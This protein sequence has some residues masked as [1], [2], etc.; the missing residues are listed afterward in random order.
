MH[1]AMTPSIASQRW[2][3]VLEQ[4]FAQATVAAGQQLWTVFALGPVRVA[5]PNFPMGLE[6]SDAGLIANPTEAFAVL[7][8]A[9]IDLLRLSAPSALLSGSTIKDVIELP[10]TRI[11]DLGAWD[12]HKLP[13]SLRR[14]LR[15]GAGAGLR[16]DPAGPSEGDLI[17]QLYLGTVSRHHGSVRYT[18][19]YFQAL[20]EAAV[21]D[22]GVQIAK[23][24]AGD[25][26]AAFIAVLHR[27][28]SSYY[29]H[30]GFDDAFS[31]IRPGYFA[32]AWAI[33]HARDRGSR[34]FEFL[35]SPVGQPAL[36]E[37]KE[38]FGGTTRPRAHWDVPLSWLGRCAVTL[39]RWRHAKP[40]LR[41][42]P[43]T[44]G[45]R[46]LHGAEQP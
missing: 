35:T 14:K 40:R 41:A 45:L 32:M 18:R 29:L 17:H 23:A 13:A 26:A 16:I 10:D 42:R 39:L 3:R 25:R 9:G 36:R 6:E 19:R 38:S 33:Q 12:A 1:S 43:T 21:G 7:R 5:Y 34:R 2:Q 24:M 15:K 4:G 37:Y 28:D 46:P 27:G 22:D 31:A 20:C 11:D 44:P 8:A 30:G